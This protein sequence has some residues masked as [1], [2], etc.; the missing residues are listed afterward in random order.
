MSKRPGPPR[1]SE[2]RARIGAS[3]ARR[4]GERLKWKRSREKLYLL[5][6]DNIAKAAKRGGLDREELDWDSY[7]KLKREIA[8]EQLQQAADRAKAK[9]RA[10]IQAQKKARAKAEKIE[11]LAQKRK[12]RRERAK[13]HGEVKRTTHKKSKEEKEELAVARE[14]K[15]K[16]RLTKIHRKKSVNGQVTSQDRKT[17]E[18]LDLELIKKGR[19]LNEASLADQ[20]RAIKSKCSENAPE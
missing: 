16:E 8:L 15:L 3:Q 10:Q 9:V 1:S 7:E 11:K 17:W 13:L 14:L 5:W 2:T 6:A 19:K 12:D 20:I 4:W 18:S